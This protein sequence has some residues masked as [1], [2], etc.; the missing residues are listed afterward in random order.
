MNSIAT[1]MAAPLVLSMAL[2]AVPATAQDDNAD[3]A[4]VDEVV[5]ETG[6]AKAETT[7]E[8]APP[9][10]I[11]VVTG[12]KA[13]RREVSAG[14]RI[15]RR[16]TFVDGVIATSTGTRGFTPGSG[17]DPAG[18]FTRIKRTRECVSDNLFLS[19]AAACIMAD[20]QEA[21]AAGK[22]VEARESYGVISGS[23]QF[24]PAERLEAARWEYRIAN[25]A[26]DAV[27]R[28]SALFTM[29]A[30]GAM[31]PAKEARA[32]R[33]FVSAALQR[34]DRVGARTRLLELDEA[35]IADYGNLANLAILSRELGEPGASATM[36]RAI[37]MRESANSPVPQ[38]WRNFAAQ[39]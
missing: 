12:D 15:A 17:M 30:T 19:K 14:S 6:E 29:I 21:F 22:L 38:S 13:V 32:R 36:L 27:A 25:E 20:A 7:A 4:V 3:E 1:I 23:A 2:V 5:V 28:E 34:G 10:N 8:P 35:G 31:D 26:G 37:E 18:R 11:I 33:S 9:S 16:P 24:A 39:E